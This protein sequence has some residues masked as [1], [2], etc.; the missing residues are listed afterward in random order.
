MKRSVRWTL[1]ASVIAALAMFVAA[2]GSSSS[3]SSST[4]SSSSRPARRT[5][6]RCYAGQEGWQA[7]LSRPPATSTT[8]TRARTTTRS[9]TWS[10]TP[11]NRPL[12]SYK[13][14]NSVKPVPDL[15]EGEPQISADKKTITVKIKQGR[16]VRARRSTA[17]SRP[18]TSSTRS[19]V[20]S[21]PNV[22]E[23]LRRRVLPVDRRRAEDA[24]TGRS[25]RSRASQTPDDNTLVFK[26]NKPQAP[27]VSRRA[28]DADHGAGAQG[29]RDEV[30]QEG[31]VDYDQHVA[32]TGPY[33]VKNDA[34]RQGHR[35]RA[36][37]ADRDRPQPELGQATRLPPRVPGLDHH[38]GGQRRPDGRAPRAQRPATG[39]LRRRRRRRRSSSRPC[40]RNK[41][42]VLLVP[43]GGTRCIALNT[44][45]KPFD[46]INV[47]KAIIAGFDR[48]ALRQ[49]RGGPV[50]GDDRQ[51]YIPP[52]IPGFEEAG[53]LKRPPT[54]TSSEPGGDMAWPRSTCRPP[55]PGV[56]VSNGKYAGAARS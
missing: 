28:R 52:G 37:Q 42:Q 38:P 56:P 9:A 49:T 35:P 10:S 17:R 50:V 14:D 4:S 53:G 27:L 45:I 29:V 11:S 6:R 55:R 32:F 22:A 43:S 30:R 24:G 51:H 3:S 36:G 44:T 46:N 26:L 12:Y 39:L 8:S 25:S 1:L 34:R 18:P 16:Q 23:R 19:S 21:S 20:P 40:T 31:A 48:N 15:A 7:H 47:R 41:D 13:P 5:R 2:C 33:M 54:S